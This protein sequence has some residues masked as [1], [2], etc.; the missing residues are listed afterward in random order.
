MIV[1]S[2]INPSQNNKGFL[3]FFHNFYGFLEERGKIVVGNFFLIASFKMKLSAR[4][5]AGRIYAFHVI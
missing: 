2:D 3:L 4:T 1:G 5:A